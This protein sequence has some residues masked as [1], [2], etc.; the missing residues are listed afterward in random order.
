[1]IPHADESHIQA[2]CSSSKGK[3]IMNEVFAKLEAALIKLSD[4]I[5]IA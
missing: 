4:I 3:K 5:R 2:G 1:L